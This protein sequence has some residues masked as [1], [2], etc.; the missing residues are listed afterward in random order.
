MDP[1]D[2]CG[3]PLYQR[4]CPRMETHRDL[5]MDPLRDLSLDSYGDPLNQGI[6]PRTETNRDLFLDLLW[7]PEEFSK[8]KRLRTCVFLSCIH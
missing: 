3:D 6:D 5:C 7:D 8:V 1:L 2:P 4:S